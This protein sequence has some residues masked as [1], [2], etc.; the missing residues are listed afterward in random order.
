MKIK[1]QKNQYFNMNKPQ[2]NIKKGLLCITNTLL[3]CAG[4]KFPSH[5][6]NCVSCY[7]ILFL[8][9]Y[10]TWSKYK[11]CYYRTVLC[12]YFEPFLFRNFLFIDCYKSRHNY[13]ILSRNSHTQCWSHLSVALVALPIRSMAFTVV[14]RQCNYWNNF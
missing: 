2:S 7:I 10:F 12:Y 8:I 11:I 13:S 4:T 1:L 3:L 6:Y 5:E 9:M 14:R